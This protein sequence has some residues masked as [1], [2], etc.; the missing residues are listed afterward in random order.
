VRKA[1]VPGVGKDGRRQDAVD[2]DIRAQLPAASCEQ[3]VRDDG[4]HPQPV[5]GLPRTRHQ[6]TPKGPYAEVSSSSTCSR[7]TFWP[8]EPLACSWTAAMR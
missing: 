2:P 7:L 3:R 8:W 4:A 5:A 1:R 6:L